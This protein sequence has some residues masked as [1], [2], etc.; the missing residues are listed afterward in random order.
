MKRKPPGKV[1]AISGQHKPDVVSQNEL[2]ELA[3]MQRMEW[4]VGKRAA[5]MSETVKTRIQHGA[6]VEPGTLYFDIE[7]EMVRTAR[8]KEGSGG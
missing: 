6:T 2:L 5:L 1:S 7:L 4:S 8:K 3:D